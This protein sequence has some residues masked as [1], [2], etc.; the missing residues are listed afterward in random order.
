MTGA[1]VGHVE[2][3]AL[4]TEARV[5]PERS[6]RNAHKPRA[7]NGRP[8]WDG[9][10]GG[11]RTRVSELQRKTGVHPVLHHYN[12]TSMRGGQRRSP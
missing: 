12:A 4:G 2:R 7:S 6:T 9:G 11:N 8:G 5:V 1:P 10:D 3:D